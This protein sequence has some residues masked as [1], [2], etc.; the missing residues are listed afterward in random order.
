LRGLT[1]SE[2][3]CTASERVFME[4]TLLQILE[5]APDEVE[6]ITWLQDA[7]GYSRERVKD[8]IKYIFLLQDQKVLSPFVLITGY[9]RTRAD[10]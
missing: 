10:D 8:A 2:P 9:A 1:A 6:I 5:P 4:D 3:T 7:L